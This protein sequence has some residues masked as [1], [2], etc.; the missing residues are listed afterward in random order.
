MGLTKPFGRI[1]FKARLSQ[2]KMPTRADIIDFFE[3][4][5]SVAERA[6]R[7]VFYLLGVGVL[8]TGYLVF[9]LVSVA[10][11]LWWNVLKGTLVAIPALIWLF[12]WSVLDSLTQAPA[13]VAKLADEDNELLTELQSLSV[14]KPGTVRGVFS[15]LRAFRRE[16]GF[17]ILFDA[18]GG[19]G[20]MVN[21]LFLLLAFMALPLL[22]ILIV[23]AVILLIF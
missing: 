10:S 21:P 23:I 4:I 12:V 16:D 20:M 3:Q 8:A 7:K 11:P 15:A 6:Q 9:E 22:L 17:G 19:I 13:S 5:A 2:I 14:N 1:L 18:V